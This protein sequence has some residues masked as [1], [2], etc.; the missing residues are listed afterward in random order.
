[1]NNRLSLLAISSVS[2]LFRRAPFSSSTIAISRPRTSRRSTRASPPGG[3]RRRPTK[4]TT[5]V[6]VPTDDDN[7]PSF[8][9]VKNMPVSLRG[10]DNTALTTLGAMGNHKALQEM[11]VRHVMA[12]DNVSYEEATEVYNQI[13]KKNHEY[14]HIMALPFQASILICAFG[15]ISIPL[16]FDLSSVEYFNEH[17]VTA[18]HPPPKELETALEVGSWAWNWMEPVLGTSTFLLLSLQYMR[19]VHATALQRDKCRC[20]CK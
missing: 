10:M 13:E 5:A 7:V 18:E 20:I 1:M 4:Q 8:A 11:I 14:E 9:T 6:A 12:T 3:T 2:R 19:Y 15:F 17:Y 16:V